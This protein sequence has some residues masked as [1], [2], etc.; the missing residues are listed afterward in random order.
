MHYKNKD[1]DVLFIA[2]SDIAVVR[3]IEEIKEAFGNPKYVLQVYLDLT[4]KH[5]GE[6]RCYDFDLAFHV[7]TNE[8]GRPV[9][10]LHT[11]CLKNVRGL[12]D[13][14]LTADQFRREIIKLG[15]NVV[16]IPMEYQLLLATQCVSNPDM[17]GKLLFTRNEIPQDLVVALADVNV[18]AVPPDSKRL[19]GYNGKD[20][21]IFGLHCLSLE[22][23]VL[24]AVDEEVAKDG[25]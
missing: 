13:G 7:M 24:V 19:I 11:D 25:L 22:G 5:G 23:R 8:N 4:K 3:N 16:D 6:S 20:F 10:L 14:V 17:P 21:P 1:K 18:E 9:A 2:H 12:P 15:F